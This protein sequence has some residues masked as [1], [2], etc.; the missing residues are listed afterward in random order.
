MNCLKLVFLW[1]CW[2]ALLRVRFGMHSYPNVRYSGV[3]AYMLYSNCKHGTC[4]FTNIAMAHECPC[5]FATSTSSSILLSCDQVYDTE[6]SWVSRAK[7]AMMDLNCLLQQSCIKLYVVATLSQLETKCIL[8]II[9]WLR[10]TNWHARPSI[11][12]ASNCNHGYDT[13]HAALSWHGRLFI[14]CNR[15]WIRRYI[16]RIIQTALTVSR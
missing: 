12:Y 8:C 6:S 16:K 4:I 2:G 3:P 13:Y 14:T 5:L 7:L 10:L 11:R 1:L 15:C 9:L